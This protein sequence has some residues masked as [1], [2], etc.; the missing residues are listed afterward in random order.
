[1]KTK[2]NGKNRHN[3]KVKIDYRTKEISFIPIYTTS[4][5]KQYLYWFSEIAMISLTTFLI[6]IISIVILMRNEYEMI[7]VTVMVGSFCFFWTL[8]LSLPFFNKKWRDNKYPKKMAHLSKFFSPS[9]RKWKKVTKENLLDNKF[10]IPQ[11]SNV[12]V[13]YRLYGDFKKVK[14]IEINNKY[15]KDSYNWSGMFIFPKIK[16]GYMEIRYI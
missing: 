2:K 11:F 3:N 15:E 13:E 5:L 6:C 7:L 1:M 12:L 16:K 14:N 9:K 10:F 8:I 4:F